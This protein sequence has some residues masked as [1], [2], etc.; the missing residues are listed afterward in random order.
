MRRYYRGI[1]TEIEEDYKM[2]GSCQAI[3]RM[4]T[5]VIIVV[6]GTCIFLR[7]WIDVAQDRDRWRALVNAV[8][9]LRVP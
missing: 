5:T 3:L 7:A 8:I 2:F 4:C 9:N 1:R 6:I